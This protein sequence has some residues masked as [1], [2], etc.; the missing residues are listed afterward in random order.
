MDEREEL[1]DVLF[2]IHRRQTRLE[3]ARS[4]YDSAR[5]RT[6]DDGMRKYGAL[7]EKYEADLSRSIETK[8]RLLE[9]N[10]VISKFPPK[11]RLEV[12]FLIHFASPERRKVILE[13]LR[14]RLKLK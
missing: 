11:Q 4:K 1:L 6:D 14:R 3:D 8:R 10:D 9:E 5:D 12:E 7:M 13:E 2:E